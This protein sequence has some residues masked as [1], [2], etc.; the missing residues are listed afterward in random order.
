M[1][2]TSGSQEKQKAVKAR[3]KPEPESILRSTFAARQ[4]TNSISWNRNGQGSSL[5]QRQCACGTHTIGG[6]ECETCQ[7]QHNSNFLQ[8]MTPSSSNQESQQRMQASVEKGEIAQ[9]N[10]IASH[11]TYEFSS[12]PIRT[13]SGGRQHLNT[14]TPSIQ[15]VRQSNMTHK[16]VGYTNIVQRLDSH[17]TLGNTMSATG[18]SRTL[19]LDERSQRRVYE[20]LAELRGEDP[21]T[22]GQAF[23]AMEP[24]A[25][26]TALETAVTGFQES[27]QGAA[28]IS[29]IRDDNQTQ[30][31]DGSLFYE[32]PTQHLSP[33]TAPRADYTEGAVRLNDVTMQALANAWP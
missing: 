5:L 15:L 14:G 18:S 32:R 2:E 10:I 13:T 12:I 22:A 9:T 21:E 24:E 30:R 1:S 3:Q 4:S 20:R 17:D 33:Y 19:E 25:R 7:R 11:P 23:E 27:T 28:L 29:E 6:G 8:R 31:P 26:A 16:T